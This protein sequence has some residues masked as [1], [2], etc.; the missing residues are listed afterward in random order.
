M[1]PSS[2]SV[3]TRSS[4]VLKV[5]STRSQVKKRHFLVLIFLTFVIGIGEFN[6]K[7]SFLLELSYI[8]LGGGGG[9]TALI[10]YAAAS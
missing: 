4:I 5:Y 9:L 8:G 3:E 7:D 10:H 6:V 1:T 2:I